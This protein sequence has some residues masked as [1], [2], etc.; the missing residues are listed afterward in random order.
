MLYGRWRERVV[1]EFAQRAIAT[2]EQ[3]ARERKAGAIAAELLGGL[4]VVGAIRRAWMTRD[5]RSLVQPP[6]QRRRALPR[7]VPGH[8]D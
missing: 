2:L 8:S 1:A 3:L 7:Q 5:L 4:L 6:A